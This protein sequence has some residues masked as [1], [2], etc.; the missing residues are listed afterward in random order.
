MKEGEGEHEHE[1]SA[2]IWE[3]KRRR[4]TGKNARREFAS[5][6]TESRSKARF[7]GDLSSLLFLAPTV[8]NT[9]SAS[10]ALLLSFLPSIEQK[11]YR[12]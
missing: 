3:R 6:S 5:S 7:A 2:R 1:S 11:Q 9:C 12:S 4:R 10:L 8:L